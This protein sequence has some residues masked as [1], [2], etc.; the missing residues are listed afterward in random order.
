M[1]GVVDSVE[2]ELFCTG[3]DTHLIL[4]GTGFGH[5]ALFEV[6]TCIP[7]N[8]TEKF[9]E[10]SGVLSLF[11]S[12]TLECFCDFGIAFAIS[13]TAHGKVHA[14]FGAFAVEVSVEVGDHLLVATFCN[15]YLMFGDELEGFIGSKLAECRFGGMAEGAFFGSLVAFVDIT[16]DGADKFLF[17]NLRNCIRS[18]FCIREC[19]GV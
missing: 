2:V 8:I 16:A 11:E 9:G 5:H 3:S 18:C 6:C 17:H 4:V 7:Y 19:R 15:A 14:D 10:F 12:I 1:N 13:L